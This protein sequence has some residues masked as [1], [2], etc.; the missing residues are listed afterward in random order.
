MLSRTCHNTINR[1]IGVQAYDEHRN[2][3]R[4]VVDDTDIAYNRWLREAMHGP[5]RNDDYA[6]NY[7]HSCYD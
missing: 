1:L 5:L 6:S 2:L 4:A 7:N 3:T